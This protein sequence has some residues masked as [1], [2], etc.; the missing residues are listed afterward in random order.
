M[1]QRIFMR[2]KID[3]NN[4]DGNYIDWTIKYCIKSKTQRISTLIPMEAEYEFFG[5]RITKTVS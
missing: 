5:G 1:T 2:K 4:S 3:T